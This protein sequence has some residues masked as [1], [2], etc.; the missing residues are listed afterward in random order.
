MCLSGSSYAK[1]HFR[2]I[3]RE[4]RINGSALPDHAQEQC[5]NGF[6]QICQI[7]Q[8]DGICLCLN[9]TYIG[10]ALRAIRYY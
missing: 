8:R 4:Y 10:K 3:V 2:H 1:G 6:D 7:V 9:Y 5:I